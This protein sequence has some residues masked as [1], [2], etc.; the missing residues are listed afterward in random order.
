M[1]AL[2]LLTDADL[3]AIGIP[4]GPR[5]KIATELEQRRMQKSPGDSSPPSSLSPTPPREKDESA[6]ISAVPLRPIGVGNFGTVWRG[7][8][9][10][11]PVAMKALNTSLPRSDLMSEAKVLSKL[12]HPNICTCY[13]A[14]RYQGLLFMVMELASGSVLSLLTDHGSELKLENLHAMALSCAAGMDYLS[15]QRVVHRDLA[16]RNLLYFKDMMT[17]EYIIKVADF[18]LAKVVNTEYYATPQSACPF[19]WSAIEA[20]AFRRFTTMS[21]VWSFGVVLWEL[22]SR[23]MEPYTGVGPAQVYPLLKSGLRLPQPSGC[24]DVIYELMRNTWLEE[25]TDRPP[26]SKLVECLTTI[27]M[28]PESPDQLPRNE[29]RVSQHIEPASTTRYYVVDGV[30]CPIMDRDD[31]DGEG[32][33][34]TSTPPATTR[35]TTAEAA[36]SASEYTVAPGATGT[37][38][39]DT[40]DEVKPPE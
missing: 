30:H 36:P 32:D 39:V 16:C 6:L 26:F 40:T 18:G 25:P 10:I 13:G 21:D 15:K 7:Q 3:K 19:K 31:D 24:P 35:N 33:E 20:L 27:V 34:T 11:T 17:G 29:L 2:F 12:R 8:W 5:R 37:I 1:D 14:C 4:L 28:K 22:Y 23:G 38:T 9:N